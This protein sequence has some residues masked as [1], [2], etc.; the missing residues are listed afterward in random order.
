MSSL[1]TAVG[2]T[3]PKICRP[4]DRADQTAAPSGSRPR[5][6]VAAPDSWIRQTIPTATLRAQTAKT[7]QRASLNLGEGYYQ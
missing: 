4:D 1:L 6:G 5:S 7:H 2:K 3:P